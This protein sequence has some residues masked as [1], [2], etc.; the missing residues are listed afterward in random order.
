MLKLNHTDNII[1]SILDKNKKQVGKIS[2]DPDYQDIEEMQLNDDYSFQVMP[3]VEKER[4]VLFVA[5]ESG[6]GKS[7]FIKEYCMQYKTIYPKNEI[8]LISY[9]DKDKTLDDYKEIKRLDAFN[10]K[11]ILNYLD[12]I[13]SKEIEEELSNCMIL[14]D[15]ID[16]ISDTDKK[17]KKQIHG[18]LNKLLKIGRH[19]NTSVMYAG[20]ELYNSPDLKTILNESTSITFFPR[21]LNFK[22]MKYLLEEYLG[23]SKDEIIKVKE[24][25]SRHIT[26]IKGYPRVLISQH[27]I[28]YLT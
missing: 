3:R 1:A 21:N 26:F 23:L 6:S 13:T 7:Y 28:F 17:I 11:E 10:N 8:Y 5:G 27:S 9:L 24:I 19:S 2:V 16:C 18:F 25:K 4:S 22:K 14:F 12:L 20:H 15:D